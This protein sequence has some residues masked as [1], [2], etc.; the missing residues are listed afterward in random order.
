MGRTYLFECPH[1]AYS[2]KVSGGADKGL[3]FTS[4]TLLCQDCKQLHDVVTGLKTA[5]TPPLCEPL[6]RK[7]LKPLAASRR[8]SPARPPS[9]AAALNSLPLAGVRHF[10]WL[11]F[12]PACPVSALHR[13]RAWT[14]PDRCPKCGVLMEKNALPF[15]IWD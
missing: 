3:R 2:A 9:F 10:K 14:Q 15:R 1:C 12:K 13:V 5:V 11:K 8:K 6:A 7:R 4:Q